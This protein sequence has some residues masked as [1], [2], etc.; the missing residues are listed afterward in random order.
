MNSE[1]NNEY[2]NLN[3]I[4]QVYDIYNF[5]ARMRQYMMRSLRP[6]LVPGKALELGCLQGDF[7]EILAREFA[8]L[9]VVDAAQTFLD[10]TRQRVGDKVRYI[11]SLFETLDLDD[12]FQNIFLVHVAEHLIDPV[13]IFRKLS[14]LLADKGRLFIIVPNGNA[15]SRQI[16]VKMGLI[17]HNT[18]LNAVD[19]KHGHRRVYCLDTL[20]SHARDADLNVIFQGGVFFKPLA[21][22]Q[23]DKLMSTDI[24]SDAYMEGCYQLGM[25]YPDLCASIFV[26]CE[27]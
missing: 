7:T 23:F 26:V 22:F 10:Q 21:N 3:Q 6:F 20:S 13:T 14:G 17:A 24:I 25:I 18:A 12:R 27:Q 9:T 4:A 19:I 15:P 16:A 8:D 1:L 5:D 2:E 11:N